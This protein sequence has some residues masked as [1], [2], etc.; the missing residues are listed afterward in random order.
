LRLSPEADARFRRFEQSIEARLGPG[1]AWHAI[2]EWA[3]KLAGA[4]LRL[5]GILQLVHN[6]ETGNPW[7]EISEN[8]LSAAIAIAETLAVHAETA[9]TPLS[10]RV[11]QKS[12][13]HLASWLA[14]QA[15]EGRDTVQRRELHQA[16][17]RHPV[18]YKELDRVLELLERHNYI[19]RRPVARQKQAVPYAVH[20]ALQKQHAPES[21]VRCTP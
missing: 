21:V 7:L 16:M 17:D 5:A 12:A 20:P 19:Q 2:V 14:G 6:V 18:S 8:T 9:F 15:A 11:R 10:E 3:S 13:L 4:T 1:R